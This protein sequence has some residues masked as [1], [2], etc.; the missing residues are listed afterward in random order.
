M[1]DLPLR[2]AEESQLFSEVAKANHTTIFGVKGKNVFGELISVPDNVQIDWMHSV[3]EGVLK[4]QLFTRW[5]SSES[6]TENYSLLTIIEELDDIILKVKVSHDLSRTPRSFIDRKKW[7]ASEFRFFLLFSGLPCLRQAV[8][9]GGLPPDNFYHFALLTT[10]M[11]HL[12]SGSATSVSVDIAQLL[13]D[14]FVRL[15]PIFY[16][17]RRVCTY[18][19][20]ALRHM[21]KQVLD[22]CPLSLTSAFVFDSFI[23][24]LKRL[25]SGTRGIPRQMV[26]R[27]GVTQSYKAHT[28]SICKGDT[29]VENLSKQFISDTINFTRC[30]NGIALFYPIVR[31]KLTQELCTVLNSHLSEDQSSYFSEFQ[32]SFR[33]KEDLTTYHRLMYPRKGNSC[34]CVVEYFSKHGTFGYGKVICFILCENIAYALLYKYKMTKLNVC[35]GIEAPKD[36]VMKAFLDNN[37]IGKDFQ[38]AEESTS[39]PIVIKCITITNR[40]MFVPFGDGKQ[41]FLTVLDTLFEHD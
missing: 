19:N 28:K 40:C 7:K 32:V 35:H 13:L 15:F 34:S 38:E 30:K 8:V 24:Q 9:L 33:M 10:A 25:F 14:N 31:R 1:N 36:L 20:H 17:S 4:R 23:A 21:P 29:K 11:R 26:D 41:G 39:T 2:K 6:A 18:N 3:C 22:N 16:G 37:L 12:H 27:F 5:F